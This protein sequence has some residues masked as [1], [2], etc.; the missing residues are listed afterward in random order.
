MKKVT[1]NVKLNMYAATGGVNHYEGT[2][3]LGEIET[4]FL[5][6]A[7]ERDTYVVV[8]EHDVMTQLT[9]KGHAMPVSF[10][11]IEREEERVAK[12]V[13]S[14][15][16]LLLWEDCPGLHHLSTNPY[17]RTI[18]IEYGIDD[19]VVIYNILTDRVSKRRV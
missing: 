14:A 9:V 17:E 15:L 5:V 4:N 10:L 3:K 8:L 19:K 7:T 1:S 16:S 12:V 2:V 11:N 18:G 6:D 13:R